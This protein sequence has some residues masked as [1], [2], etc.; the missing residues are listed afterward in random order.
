M[1]ALSDASVVQQWT[2]QLASRGSIP[3]FLS[4]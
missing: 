2:Q 1:F 4:Q 3:F